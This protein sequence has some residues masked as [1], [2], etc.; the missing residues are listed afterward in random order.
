MATPTPTTY[1][2]VQTPEQIGDF[3]QTPFGQI[4]VAKPRYLVESDSYQ[5]DVRPA[6]DKDNGTGYSTSELWTEWLWDEN[7]VQMPVGDENISDA[8]E[9]AIIQTAAPIS[10]KIVGFHLTRIGGVPTL[11]NP[12]P[13]NSNEKLVG[14]KIKVHAPQ[15]MADFEN[16][17]LE[18]TGE[19]RYKMIR[20]V[21]PR[22]GELSFGLGQ[23]RIYKF[24][25]ADMG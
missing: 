7:I 6:A 16:V 1:D 11:P 21:W 4:P 17:R 23:E 13:L 3:I 5:P 8:V 20:P 10:G 15:F 12:N 19:Y 9:S 25:F 22:S 18:V 2:V 14:I 24:N